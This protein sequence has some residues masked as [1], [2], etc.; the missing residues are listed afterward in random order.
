MYD[1]QSD[2]CT[3]FSFAFADTVGCPRPLSGPLVALPAQDGDTLSLTELAA[4]ASRLGYQCEVNRAR[5][6][7]HDISLS[8]ALAVNARFGQ[9]LIISCDLRRDPP[10]LFNE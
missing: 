8:D 3:D 10:V 6:T 9:Q 7:V 1:C 4:F 2:N 5:L